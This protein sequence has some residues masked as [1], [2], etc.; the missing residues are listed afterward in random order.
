MIEIDGRGC[1]QHGRTVVSVGIGTGAHSPLVVDKKIHATHLAL[2]V[3]L[4]SCVVDLVHGLSSHVGHLETL[5][6]TLWQIVVDNWRVLT[7][8]V[9][10][11]NGGV[12]ALR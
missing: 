6:R 1:S 12:G 3:D 10:L 9:V 5:S 8:Q 2:F 11:H 4:P 7:L